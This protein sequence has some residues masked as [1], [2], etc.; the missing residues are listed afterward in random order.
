MIKIETNPDR[1]REVIA[2]PENLSV[3][4]MDCESPED[5]KPDLNNLHFIVGNGLV[6]YEIHTPFCAELVT[7]LSSKDIPDNPIQGLFE[8]WDYLNSLGI[9]T[10]YTIVQKDNIRARMMC[11]AA[12]MQLHSSDKI[13]TYIQVIS[14]GS[15]RKN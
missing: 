5:Y 7:A 14:D 15:Y 12:G 10:V 9:N 3:I 2:R 6:I 4:A 8:Q 11:R 1:I 13:N